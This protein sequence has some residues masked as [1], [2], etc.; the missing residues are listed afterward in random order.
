MYFFEQILT[1]DSCTNFAKKR[2]R[3]IQV[4]YLDQGRESIHTSGVRFL[5]SSHKITSLEVMMKK[6]LEDTW[7][8]PNSELVS[9]F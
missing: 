7:C 6:K 9:T 3:F 8:G 1:C 2:G 5:D 4:H